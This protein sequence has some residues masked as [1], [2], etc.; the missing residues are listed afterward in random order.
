MRAWD[1]VERYLIAE[2]SADLADGD[3]IRPCLVA[4]RDEQPL[5]IAFLRS[6]ARG[7]YADPVIELLALAAPL[8]A[9]RLALS[10]GGRA[11]S[12]DDP[13][14]PVVEAFGDLRQRVLSVTLAEE[15]GGD[16]E[17]RGVIVPFTRDDSGAVWEAAV[18]HP[19]GEGWISSAL[20]MAVEQRAALAATPRDMRRQARRCVALGHLLALSDAAAE[21]LD[22]RGIPLG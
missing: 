17:V 13:I 10:F 19:G 22:V 9:N 2:A 1:D 6:F 20:R 12:W 4:W 5:F 14:P 21:R 8:G 7:Q 11:W 3:D 15:R 18:R 16:V